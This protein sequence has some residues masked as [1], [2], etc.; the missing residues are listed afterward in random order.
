MSDVKKF[1]QIGCGG[2]G[3]AWLNHFM[4]DT[5]KR[6]KIKAVAVVDVNPDVFPDAMAKYD[7]PKEKCYT[8]AEK[9]FAE[10]EADFAVIVVP[11]QY[12]EQM[13]DLVLKYDMDILSEK[14]IADTMEACCRVYKKVVLIP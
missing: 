9:A 2:F 10:N 8:D 6:K 13:F 11:P 7:L 12:H 5:M 4:P 14:P 1:I 3:G